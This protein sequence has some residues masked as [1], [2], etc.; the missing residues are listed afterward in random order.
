[1]QIPLE[2]PEHYKGEYIGDLAGEVREAILEDDPEAF[3]R[4]DLHD[5]ID[6]YMDKL[7]ILG[8]LVRDLK[9]STVKMGITFDRWFSEERELHQTGEVASIL[10]KLHQSGV[11]EEKDGAVWLKGG[12]DRDRVLVKSDGTYTYLLV[13]LAYHWNK[14]AV[15]K[16]D[17]VINLWGADHAG[18]VPSL[19]AGL[20]AL[21]QENKL[22]VI[23]FQLVRLLKDG[24]E[25]KVSKRAGTYVTIDELIELTG[26]SDVAR[27]FFLTRSADTQ[28][29]FDLDLAKEQSQKNPYWYVM[30]S[31]ARA[32][33]ILK[34][35]TE[36][37][38]KI[39]TGINVLSTQE[40]TLI[41]QISQF[42]N[43]LEVIIHDYS[44]HKLT[45]FAM[46][47]A[48]CFHDF[49][50]SEKII[51]LPPEKAAERLYLIQ[52]YLT[53]MNVYFD[54]MGI[55]PIERMD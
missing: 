47:V 49:Y 9:A 45:F 23:L 42:P 35:A 50:E 46:E 41:K 15:R 11:T 27:F 36:K 24:N 28:M 40:R 5:L 26:S 21:G 34:Q 1:M 8:Q 3:G 55:T 54:L 18:Q 10:K 53:F 12:D 51:A 4:E 25:Y 38:L 29:D 37:G 13:D 17:K 30:Y 52:Q 20:K 16:F 43:L 33:S 19:I 2:I 48:K 31:Y 6:K 32:H 22:D 44:V 14:L 39:G 7:D